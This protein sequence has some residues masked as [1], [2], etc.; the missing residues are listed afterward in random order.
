MAGVTVEEVLTLAPMAGAAVIGGRA[1]GAVEA[2]RHGESGL[3]VNGEAVD[4]IAGAINSVLG[5]D[6]LR[7][8]LEAGA[9]RHAQANSW[10]NRVLIFQD[11]CKKLQTTGEHHV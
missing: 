4:E 2:V 3:L 11:L 6:A 9:L 5:D 7:A 8:R 10:S 1:G